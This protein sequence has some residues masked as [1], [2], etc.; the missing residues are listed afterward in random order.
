VLGAVDCCWASARNE[1]ALAYREQHGLKIA[2]VRLAVLVQQLGLA[3]TSAVVF[4]ANPV[5]GTRWSRPRAGGSG[6]AGLDNGNA[7][8]LGYMADE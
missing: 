2:A 8:Y 6:R 5:T 4:S 3:N 7:R 1:R